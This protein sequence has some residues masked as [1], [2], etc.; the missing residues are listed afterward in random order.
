MVVIYLFLDEDGLPKYVGK[1]NNFK[2]RL[3]QH[4][5]KDRFKYNTYFYRWLNKCIA[6]NKEFYVDILEECLQENWQEKEKYWIK[7]FRELGYSITNM[8]DGGD[9]N[10][11]QIFSAET[12]LKRKESNKG[13]KHT[14][15]AKKRMSELAKG[16]VF[17]KETR[18]KLSD[19]NKGR[20]Y[21]EEIKLKTSK[22]VSREDLITK[23]VINFVSLTKAASSIPTRKS[24]LANA[25]KKVNPV[26]AGYKWY[27]N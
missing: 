25:M 11:N 4:L 16:K 17:S 7:H 27:Y 10:N 26:F 22:S 21:P 14:E 5:N 6:N 13:F 24:T 19:I 12:I 18:K 3:K 8:T 1:S 2:S 9:G 15:E 20:F 23:E